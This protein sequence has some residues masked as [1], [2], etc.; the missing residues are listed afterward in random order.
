MVVVR[1]CGG[2]GNIF[3]QYSFGKALE[4]AGNV[5]RFDRSYYDT[6]FSRTYTLD[7]WNTRVEFAAPIGEEI[8]EG[9]L[10]Y[11]PHLIRRYPQDCTFSGYWQSPHYLTGI[12][13]LLRQEFT[14]KCCPSP[15]S[16]EVAGQILKTNSVF[17]HI[18]K[19][20][21]LAARGLAFHGLVPLDYYERAIRWIVTNSP[22]PIG[23]FVFS[24]DIEW[25]KENLPWPVTFVDHNSTGVVANSEYVLTR[26]ED[27]TEHEDLWLLSLCKHGITAN[28]S[29]SWWGG[30]LIKNPE[31]IIVSPEAWFTKTHNAESR[32]MV[33]WTRM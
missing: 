12:E 13:P 8:F 23:L 25:C 3:W 9:T 27:G 28:S 6:D 1:F 21:S 31:K 18:R 7:H 26:Q 22:E 32:D 24:D 20:D 30:W 16:L 15:R 2:T 4:L 5:V 33:N 29:F 14:L 17:L 11:Q 10:R 19:T